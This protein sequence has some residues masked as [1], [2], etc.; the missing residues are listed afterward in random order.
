MA[1]TRPPAKRTRRT[2]AAAQPAAEPPQSLV[3]YI[4]GVG[5]HP[6]APD[7]KLQWD[8]ALFGRD[9]GEHSRMAYWS[10]LLHPP[11]AASAKSAGARR[12]PG[13]EPPDLKTVLVAAGMPAPS[14]DALQLAQALA[15]SLGVPQAEATASTRGGVHK[16][17]LPLPA[18]LRKP[19]SR[20]FLEAFVGD[21]AAYFFRTGMRAKILA[22]LSKVLDLPKG[23]PIT[24]IA[25]SQGSVIAYELLSALK[26]RNVSFVV[27]A[28]VTIGSPLGIREVQD[29]LVP[30]DL[31]I[32]PLVKR[33]YNFSDPLDPVA[34]DKG[35]ASDF[36]AAHASVQDEIVR[37]G[38]AR[39]IAG[40]NPHSAV[41]YLAHPR[42]RKVVNDAMHTDLMARFV[43]ARDVAERLGS[44]ADSRHPVL[45]EVLEPGYGALGEDADKLRAHELA[46]AKA[47]QTVVQRRNM[48]PS[49][50]EDPEPRTLRL[51]QRVKQ[52]ADKLETLVSDAEAACIDP[53]R[54]FVAAR[55]TPAELQAVAARHRELRVYAVWQSSRKSKFT[56][57]RSM[58]AIKADAALTSFSADG[59]GITWAVLDT[60]VRMDHPH[61]AGVID[62]V[63]DC[64][65]RGAPV[66]LRT[67]RDTDGHGSHVSGIIAGA[68]L[69]GRNRGVAPKARL[70][71]YKVL[72]DKGEGEDA[73]IIKALDHIART[74]E[75]MPAG[76]AVH[77][78]N[79]SLGSPFDPS[80]Y[81]CGFS[82]LCTE[83]RRLWRNGVLAVVASGNEGM[84]ELSTSDGFADIATS[85]SIGDPAN[86]EEC[87]AVGAVN[88]DNPHTY[89]VW[90]YS[91]RGPTADGRAKP[92]LVAPGERVVSCNSAFRGPRSLY[93][94]DSGTSMAAPHVSG[95]LAAFLSVRR[96][97]RGR[98]DDVKR[99]LLKACTDLGRDRYHQGHG[100][101]NLMQML[102][103][104]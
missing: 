101:P 57:H 51:E 32:P 59:R 64:T 80:V 23:Q 46:E 86:L 37:N 48:R 42:V 92:D 69:D 98:P 22:R 79:L 33:W 90:A 7:L 56:D 55:L 5:E 26:A 16:K 74:N 15:A 38:Q 77:G 58:R 83:L 49:D 47:L 12:G 62:S 36:S 24:L 17:V 18:W 73:W 84:R 44:E 52:L 87:I 14:S 65:R 10:D 53:L 63:W 50:A 40:F 93:R 99:L 21:T 6:P 39:H 94:E 41:G 29:F 96:E 11:T 91:S 82:P 8:L 66:A 20:R 4:H 102:L 61:F 68:S 25:H 19:I 81:G 88:C 54:R 95:L 28:F 70:V 72:N 13:T 3:V 43:V 34:L 60:G 104:V 78:V 45:I 97:F 30:D 35:L 67:D 75:N 100:L 1:S 2:A 89:G 31:S 85:M 9:M 27:D 71:V 76:Q 103:N